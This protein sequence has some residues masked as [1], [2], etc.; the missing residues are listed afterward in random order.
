M[1]EMN[2]IHDNASGVEKKVELTEQEQ[3]FLDILFDEHKGNIRKAMDASGY[4]K[5]TPTSVVT[6][7][8]KDK[9]RAQSEIYLASNTAKAVIAITDV[10]ENPA[11]IGAANA[12]KAAKE[13]LDRSGVVAPETREKVVERN[14]FILPPKVI[15]EQ[16]DE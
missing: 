14:I 1:A 13:V 4:P 11:T 2:K 9:I 7:K 6:N 16:S 8:L 3:K 10:I 15:H 12:L 5:S